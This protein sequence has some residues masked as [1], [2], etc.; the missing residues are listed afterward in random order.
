MVERAI[1]ACPN[2]VEGVEVPSH[3]IPTRNGQ[4]DLDAVS[5][6]VK[7][8]VEELGLKAQVGGIAGSLALRWPSETPLQLLSTPV[9]TSHC[10]TAGIS[11]LREAPLPNLNPLFSHRLA[12][13]R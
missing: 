11:L 3:L 13:E 6:P 7:Q 12:P 10:C 2:G 1:S 4:L 9:T 5:T 8:Q